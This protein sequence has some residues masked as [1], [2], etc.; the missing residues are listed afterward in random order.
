M[1][2]L[3]SEEKSTDFMLN[4]ALHDQWGFGLAVFEQDRFWPNREVGMFPDHQAAL[5]RIAVDQRNCDK[6][7]ATDPLPTLRTSPN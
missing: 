7:S 3:F 6:L 2:G 4:R 5:L 1:T